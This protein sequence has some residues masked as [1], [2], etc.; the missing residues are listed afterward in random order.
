M[1][2]EETLVVRPKISDATVSERSDCCLIIFGWC[3][4]AVC[5]CASSESSRCLA[6]TSTELALVSLLRKEGMP[7][8][9]LGVL[10]KKLL[11]LLP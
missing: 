1:K 11:L 5:C 3:M 6:A 4:G 8:L 2:K 9:L 10:R 7:A